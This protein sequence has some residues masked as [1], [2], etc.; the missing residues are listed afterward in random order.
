M[1]LMIRPKRL[2]NSLIRNFREM[3]KHI[4]TKGNVTTT[5]L[6]L[7]EGIGQRS[8]EEILSL[9]QNGTLKEYSERLP[10]GR[11]ITYSLE[12]E[13]EILEEEEE[14]EINSSR[15]IGT[16]TAENPLGRVDTVTKVV[17]GEEIIVNRTFSRTVSSDEGT[18]EREVLTTTEREGGSSVS[19]NRFSTSGDTHTG[20]NQEQ[21]MPRERQDS[22]DSNTIVTDS[23]LQITEL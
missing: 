10:D 9:T 16:C 12:I 19:I 11:I 22:E 17:E 14:I 21:A 5:L 23:G 3:T 15:K 13:E 6:D 18:R 2:F 4:F 1:T 7:T 8:P 20:E